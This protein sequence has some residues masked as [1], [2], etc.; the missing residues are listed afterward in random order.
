MDP[1]HTFPPISLRSILL[2]SF[3]LHLGLLHGLFSS[4]LPTKILYA[5]LISPMEFG[6]ANIKTKFFLFLISNA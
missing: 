4:G 6:F 1:F 3:Y 5:F 2:S